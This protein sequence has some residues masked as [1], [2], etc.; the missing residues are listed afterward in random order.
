MKP[1]CIPFLIAAAACGD[2]P[3]DRPASDV[4]S[5]APMTM[6]MTMPS[7][8]MM[9]PMRLR[10]AALRTATPET[11]A[12]LLANHRPAVDS[13]LGTMAA[14]MRAMNMDADPA[15]RALED[16]VRADL[17]AL[18]ALEGETL[19]L[20]VRAHT[21]RLGRLMGQHEMMMRM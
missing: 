15:W 21:G 9:E 19:M 6:S 4:G 17:M 16:S 7:L 13:L 3:A 12:D 20:R 10:L 5:D 8:D 2:A 14:D 1:L 11:L 18:P